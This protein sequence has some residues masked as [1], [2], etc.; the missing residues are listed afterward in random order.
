MGRPLLHVTPPSVVFENMAGPRNAGEWLYALGLA[1][2]LGET[3]RSQAAYAVRGFVGSAVTV[4]LSFNTVN[5]LSNRAV[6]G[7]CHVAPPS[8]ERLMM[9]ELAPPNAGPLALKESAIE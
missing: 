7:V 5:E 2:S 4:S 9:I 1:C 8:V 3:S 6:T